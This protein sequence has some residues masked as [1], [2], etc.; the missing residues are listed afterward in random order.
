TGVC[1][2]T[3]KETRSFTERT[4]VKFKNLTDEEI[5]YY[6]DHYRPYDKAGAYGIQEW[7]GMVG[8]SGIQGCYYNVMGLPVA[9][10]FEEL[11]KIAG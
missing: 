9:R 3:H 4:D 11:K 6:I 7:I 10:L 5:N 8:I 2:R 1:L